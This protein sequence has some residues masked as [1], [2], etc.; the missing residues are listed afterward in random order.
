M[1]CNVRDSGGCNAV[2]A[3]MLLL[4]NGSDQPDA[5]YE[6]TDLTQRF[7]AEIAASPYNGDAWAW[8]RGRIT[9][10]NY[11]GI[12]IK[13]YIPF[14]TSNNVTLNAEVAG[15]NTYKGYG[16]TAVGNHIDFI[17][18]ELWRTRKRLNPVN[19]NNGLIPIETLTGDGAKTEFVLT[20]EMDGI[21]S[22]TQG[23]EGLTGYSYDASTF[24]LTFAE[25]PAA[26]TI[27]VTG[28]GTEY[29]WLASD[30][31]HWLNSL[32]GQV[33]NGTDLNPAV[34]HVDYT[35][36]GL[37][38]YLPQELKSVIVEK[39]AYLPKRYSASGLLSDDNSGGWE[40]IGKLWLPSE[41]EVY[42][43]PVWG[44]KGGHST[45]GNCVQYPIFVHNMSRVKNRGGSRDHWWVLSVYSG[46]PTHWCFVGNYGNPGYNGASNGSI[47]APVCFRIS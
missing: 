28:T 34:T 29:P 35:Q 36:D 44:G 20:R 26:G 19:Y 3:A 43:A 32:S 7:A 24:T 14:T 46:A 4:K 31:Y 38:Y 13:D 12:N 18:R 21:A 2:D 11:S 16:D 47:A 1:G 15:I 41:F 42:G 23:G 9:A 37:Y 17:C 5:V 10:G 22:V 8:I 27:T 45:A 33:P 40:N 6:G 39:R 25:A 30:L